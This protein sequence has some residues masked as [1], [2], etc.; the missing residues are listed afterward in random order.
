MGSNLCQGDSVNR[1]ATFS[2]ENLNKEKLVAWQPRECSKT[3]LPAY[4]EKEE[5]RQ[6]MKWLKQWEYK[7]NK[8]NKLCG[9]VTR[10]FLLLLTCGRADVCA[11]VTYMWVHSAGTGISHI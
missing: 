2:P 6:I 5:G 11:H 4:K 9:F 3:K 1:Y 10:T 7:R 8:D